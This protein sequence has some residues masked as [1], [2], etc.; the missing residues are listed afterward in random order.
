[1]GRKTGYRIQDTEHRRQNKGDAMDAFQQ[2]TVWLGDGT[3]GRRHL[4]IAFLASVRN[5][6][7]I[8]KGA[9]NLADPLLR[10]LFQQM[11]EIIGSL[12]L[13]YRRGNQQKEPITLGFEGVP[14]K[15]EKL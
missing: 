15:P 13:A 3:L 6:K 1:M 12:D 9:R 14:I 8:P 10:R 5:Q 4:S 2:L 11:E 7:N